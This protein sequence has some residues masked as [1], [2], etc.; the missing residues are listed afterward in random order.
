MSTPKT[1][2]LKLTHCLAIAGE[3]CQ[4]GEIVELLEHEAKDLLNRGKAELATPEEVGGV[5]TT[6]TTAPLQ[7]PGVP[8]GYVVSDS[9]GKWG[10]VKGDDSSEPEAFAGPFDTQEQAVADA[11]EHAAKA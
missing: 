10:W 4:P 1:F 2:F 9:E 11:A 8:S 6:P 7:P 5:G 3:I